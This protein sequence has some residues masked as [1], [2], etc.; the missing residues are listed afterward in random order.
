MTETT[1]TITITVQ[2]AVPLQRLSD[3]VVQLQEVK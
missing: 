2:Q 3:R 1:T